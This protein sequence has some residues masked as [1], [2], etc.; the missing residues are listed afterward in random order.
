VW[1]NFHQEPFLKQRIE[2]ALAPLLGLPLTDSWRPDVEG[3]EALQRF[4]FGKQRPVTNRQGEQITFGDYALHIGCPWRVIGQG[5][6]LVAYIDL[7][8]SP[9][10]IEGGDAAD[11][12]DSYAPGASQR[13]R[14]MQRFVERLEEAPVFVESIEAD[15]VGSV[16][17]DL[18]REY[19][20]EILPMDS[21]HIEFWRLLDIRTGH[22][23]AKHFVVTG[24]GIEE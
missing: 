24:Q 22:K 1:L 14:A 7:Y 16:R 9:D 6:I 10:Q 11:D 18:S 5:R 3:F 17:F 13:D 2:A 19:R 15:E 23:L 20:L 4:E 21:L 8:W 12:F